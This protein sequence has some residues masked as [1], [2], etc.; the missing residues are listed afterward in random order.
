MSDERT[1]VIDG[2]RLPIIEFAF[3]GPLRDELVGAVLRGEKTSTTGLLVDFE[4]DGDAVPNP[5]ERYVMIDSDLRPV[6]IIETVEARV[7]ACGEVDEAFAR[8]EGEGFDSV[9]DWRAAHERFW[10]G[11][12]D[13]IRG[14][15]GDPA[16]R[17]TDD[18]PVVAER[19]RLV[20]RLDA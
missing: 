19:F 14:Y 6:G 15:L 7:I 11:Y 18:T 12:A 1:R 13:E 8:D 10:D 17:V 3:P 16:W 2:E 9:A 5:G 20:R 4:R